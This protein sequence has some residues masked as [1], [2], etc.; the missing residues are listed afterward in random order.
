M[1]NQ[2]PFYLPACVR[3]YTHYISSNG[4]ILKVTLMKLDI[5]QWHGN[6]KPGNYIAELKNLL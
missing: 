4:L 3:L 6:L 2:G 5:L 1:L